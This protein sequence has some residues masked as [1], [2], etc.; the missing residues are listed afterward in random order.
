MYARNCSDVIGCRSE[1]R[2]NNTLDSAVETR[3]IGIVTG[4]SDNIS[5]IPRAVVPD[6]MHMH[7]EAALS[8][9]D[10]SSQKGTVKAEL[11]VLRRV[12]ADHASIFLNLRPAI[13]RR[14][15]C[16]IPLNGVFGRGPNIA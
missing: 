7:G 5:Q 13:N 15:S 4:R 16:K 9:A 2:A 3:L 11:G 12:P 1:N 14:I 10:P 6:L 8:S